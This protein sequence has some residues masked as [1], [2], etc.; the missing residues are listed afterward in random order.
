MNKET[1]LNK[2]T[3]IEGIIKQLKDSLDSTKE[4]VNT[5]KEVKLVDKDSKLISKLIQLQKANNSNTSFLENLLNNGY[6]TL[7]IGQYDIVVK[8]ANDHN[9][10]PDEYQRMY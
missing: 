10:S 7:T 6:D 4:V 2:L 9:L 3:T 8:I 1:I 5:N